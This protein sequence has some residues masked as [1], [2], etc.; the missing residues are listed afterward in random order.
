M[1]ATLS[2]SECTI[3][4][5]FARPGGN[6]DAQAELEL[7]IKLAREAGFVFR[8]IDTYLSDKFYYFRN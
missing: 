1:C 8:T 4:K 6:L 7:F 5:L 2:L 3:I